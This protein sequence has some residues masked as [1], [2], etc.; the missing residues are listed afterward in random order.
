MMFFQSFVPRPECA[1]LSGMWRRK[2][3]I[4]AKYSKYKG[5]MMIPRFKVMNASR[6]TI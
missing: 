5:L 3:L 4:V 6:P 2:L 1:T